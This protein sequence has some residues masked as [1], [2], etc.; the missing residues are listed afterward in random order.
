[1]LLRISEDQDTVCRV[2]WM[3]IIIDTA[4]HHMFAGWGLSNKAWQGSYATSN[5]GNYT[6]DCGVSSVILA[7]EFWTFLAR[8]F[9]FLGGFARTDTSLI[10]IF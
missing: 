10:S 4:L 1:M 6:V 8:V 5:S 3:S 7:Q 2:V 9:D